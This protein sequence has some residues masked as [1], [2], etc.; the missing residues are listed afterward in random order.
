MLTLSIIGLW[1]QPVSALD[2]NNFHISS[3]AVDMKLSRNGQ[4]RSTLW[5]KETITADFPT[6]DQ[7]HGL[8]RAFVTSYD[9]H[10]TK[11][12]IVSV[13][14]AAGENLKYSM[15]ND[16]MRIGDAD[17]Y[18][19][20]TQ[21]YVIIYTQQDV[22][23]YYANTGRDEFYW[24]VIGHEW[25]VP[26]DTAVINL[27]V[28][29]TLSTTLTGDA[30][31]YQG[32]SGSTEACQIERTDEGYTT[33]LGGFQ[34]YDG[35]TIA[36][37][38]KASTFTAYTPSLFERVVGIWF[39]VQLVGL[40]AAL[41]VLPV[42]AVRQRNR[43]NRKKEL[44]GIPAEFLPPEDASVTVSSK[45]GTEARA[46]QTAQLLDLAVRRYVKIYETQ[47]KTF[48]WP[49]KYEIEIAKDISTL[50]WEEREVLEDA[51]GARPAVGSR[52]DL[53]SLRNN[54]AYYFRTTNND[55]DLTK[56][57]RGEYGLRALDEKEQGK[58]QRKAG[59]FLL[60]G[61]L[62]LSPVFLVFAA[63]YFGLSFA[64]WRLTDKGLELRRY[65]EG[66]KEYIKMA[67]TDRIKTLQS[68]EGAEKVARVVNG[69]DEVQL[70]KLYERV[71]PYAVLFGLEKEWNEQLGRYYETTNSQ[72]GWYAGQSGVF[73][74]AVFTSA[75]SSFSSV[76]N[77]ASSS[78]SSSGGSMG[79]G[80]SGG[81]GGGG[82]GGGW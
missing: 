2:T 63:T 54:T 5:T 16:V 18:V 7:N 56:L 49:A 53:T 81:G 60:V 52:L 43:M 12:S 39:V 72:P 41:L 1:V 73:N 76:S 55:S 44:V 67:E 28:D 31:C 3:Y 15:N 70:I 33:T 80:F 69:T 68:P 30:A 20:G 82:G 40:F 26:I 75:M 74:A 61:L 23:R 65:L 22:T 59:I 77:Y 50:R 10:P 66:L 51:F 24:D 11:L 13:T 38:F 62:T 25:G 46:V 32:A 47:Q 8:E 64:C 45:I 4:K 6:Y 78:S 17:R 37:G 19:H 58:L 35:V 14:N 42:V 27:N 48:I 79:G 29:K 34:P 57:I 9:G 71:L 21:T 36:V